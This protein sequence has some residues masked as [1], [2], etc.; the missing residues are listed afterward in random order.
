MCESYSRATRA[1]SRANRSELTPWSSSGASIFTAT[2]RPS[3]TCVATNKRDM[4]PPTE[5]TFERVTRA[6]RRLKFVAQQ[7]QHGKYGE[8]WHQAEWRTAAQRRREHTTGPGR[9]IQQGD[10]VERR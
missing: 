8:A 6:E 10:S 7:I 9:W 2:C 3:A 1:T 5:L 4:P